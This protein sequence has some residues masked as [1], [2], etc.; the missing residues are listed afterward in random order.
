MVPARAGGSGNWEPDQGASE[1]DFAACKR[2]GVMQNLKAFSLFSS[3]D[4]TRVSLEADTIE[5]GAFGTRGGL[6]QSL[7]ALNMFYKSRSSETSTS[8]F[9]QRTAETPDETRAVSLE[10][11][12][13]LTWSLPPTRSISS[14]GSEAP[15]KLAVLVRARSNA[16]QDRV[17]SMREQIE[18]EARTKQSFRS[19]RSD[20]NG[21]AA[22]RTQSEAGTLLQT[23]RTALPGSEFTMVDFDDVGKT[24]HQRMIDDVGK[25]VHQRMIAQQAEKEGNLSRRRRRLP[26]RTL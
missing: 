4:A 15:S 3:R 9:S 17:R 13:P 8:S 5:D 22:Q 21:P 1:D 11:S 18:Q 12:S 14:Q 7:R 20:R 10:D 19:R 25:T 2:S 26:P 6:I 23:R 24:V 16:V